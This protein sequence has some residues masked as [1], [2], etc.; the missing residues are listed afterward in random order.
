MLRKYSVATLMLFS[1]IIVNGAF[2]VAQARDKCASGRLA[3]GHVC[4]LEHNAGR[5]VCTGYVCGPLRGISAEYC[6]LHPDDP[7]CDE[8]FRRVKKHL[9]KSH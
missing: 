1:A 7:R 2:D 6:E 8:S 5:G 9:K 4:S 3:D